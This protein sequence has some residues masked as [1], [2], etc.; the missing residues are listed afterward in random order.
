MADGS[1]RTPLDEAATVAI[2]E[3]LATLEVEAIAVCFLWSIVN[4][5]H[6]L[7]VGR[8]IEKHL[9]EYSL[10][11]LASDQSV[12]PRIPARH[13][14]RDRR[15]AEADHDGLPPRPRSAAARRR[16]RRP[17]ADHHLAG[18]RH[19]CGEHRRGAGAAGQFRAEPRAGRGARLWLGGGFRHADRRRHRRHHLRRI[20][21]PPRP[22]S[23]DARDLAR[24]PA[25]QP[26][27]RDALGR[28][29]QHRRR[30]RLHRLRRSRRP[31][32]CRSDQRRRR[33][34]AGRLR[35]RRHAGRPSPT[36]RLSSASSTPISS[37][38]ATWGSIARRRRRRSGA[39]SPIRSA[40]RSRKPRPRSST[41]ATENMVQA[42][43]DITVNQG[44]DPTDATFV[45][46]GGAGGLNCVAIARRLGCRRVLVP[47]VGAALA[48]AGALISDLTAR[49]HAMFHSDER[50]LRRRR[51]ERGPRPAGS[52][53]A[54]RSPVPARCAAARSTGRPRRAIPTRPGR[55][56]C[57]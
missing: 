1:V 14:D 9:P 13:V 15:L 47:E 12:D 5:E 32:P 57:R 17:R 46:G 21:G 56:K 37:S 23:A 33:A 36:P 11:A 7:A 44:I 51:G 20:A 26:H 39:T 31:P 25:R 24:P 27:D 43:M 40:R 42:I 19:G 38:A 34:R 16:L 29:A 52:S 10:H 2:L 53:A 49:Y 4:P 28:R 6:E 55:S 41:L 3:R 22:H 48:A 30:R 18:R 35:S 54:R 45:A 50:R 8:L